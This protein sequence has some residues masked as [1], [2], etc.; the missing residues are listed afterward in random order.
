MK[1]HIYLFE[2]KMINKMKVLSIVVPCYNEQTAIKIFYNEIIK[3]SKKLQPKVEFE[4]IF[5]DDGSRDN[6]LHAIK[7]ISKQDV[8]VKYISFSRNFGKESAM[9]A[10]LKKA[11]GGLV[12]I[13]D[14]DLQDPPE[15]LYDMYNCIINGECDCVA[16][17]RVT[18]KGEPLIRSFFAR[19]FYSLVNKVSNTQIV[20]GA[21]YYRLMTRQMVDSIISLK[22][23]NR[24]SKGIFSW[25]GYNTKWI[26]YE[27]VERVTGETKWS[28]WKLFIYS[29]DGIIAFSTAPLALASVAGILLCFLA[30]I[31]ICIIIVKTLVFGDPVDGYPSLICVI[32]FIG[33]VQ[34]FCIGILGQY[35]AR[36]YLETKKRPLYIIKEES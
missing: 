34:L 1:V 26:E 31:F 7:E 23:Y 10:G 35:I 2:V 25:V 36:I 21:R 15:L 14:V 33:G 28:F 9:Y 22:E 20:D 12:A 29:L 18:R 16:A 5:V 8:R 27:N 17:R 30:F 4:I 11:K 24:F 32:M 3:V 19:C 13:M 6:T